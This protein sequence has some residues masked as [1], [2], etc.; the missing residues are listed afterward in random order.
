M[1]HSRMPSSSIRKKVRGLIRTTFS[2]LSPDD[3][4]HNDSGNNDDELIRDKYGKYIT[5]N[6]TTITTTTNPCF[7]GDQTPSTP[8][9]SNSFISECIF[10]RYANFLV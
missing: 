5:S 10:K 1:N 9:S 8:T 4:N 2:S 6:G 7:S 3:D